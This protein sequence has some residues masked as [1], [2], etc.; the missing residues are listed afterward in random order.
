MYKFKDDEN[1]LATF[2]EP[3]GEL[4]MTEQMSLKRGLKEFGEDGAKVVIKELKQ[5]DYLDAIKPV[6]A[7]HVTREQKKAALRYLMY[8]KQKRCGQIKAR[9]C[10]DEAENLQNQGRDQLSHSVNRGTISHINH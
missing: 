5:L 8:L 10:A 4:F 6:H 3:M 7:R 2:H 1:L 9:G